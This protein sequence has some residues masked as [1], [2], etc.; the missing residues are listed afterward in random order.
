M[1]KLLVE[2]PIDGNKLKINLT[3]FNIVD[4]LK[5]FVDGEINA[6]GVDQF[7][8]LMVNAV[9]SGYSN[10]VRMEGYEDWLEKA[11]HE[12]DPGLP[13]CIVG[14]TRDYDIL[15]V[16]IEYTI[17][18]GNKECYGYGMTQ[19]TPG[20]KQPRY[21]YVCNGSV[22]AKPP[23]NHLTLSASQG[24]IIKGNVALYSF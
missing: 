20:N 1:R 8:L 4:H 7:I 14:R 13:G 9:K 10:S 6:K 19:F 2:L 18:F 21:R 17:S 3:E 24:G 23:I 15:K 16:S 12:P 11:K 22:D 5:I